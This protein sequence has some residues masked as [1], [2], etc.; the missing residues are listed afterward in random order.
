MPK[1]IKP[2]VTYY[3]D[4][5]NRNKK[6]L[7]PIKANITINY[8]NSSKII[9]HTLPSDWNSKRQ[10]VK[11][12]RPGK[13][14]NHETINKKLEMVQND[15]EN[16]VD[17][18]FL[19][20][21]PLTPDIAKQFFQG[22]R[23]ATEKSFW[24]AYEEYIAGLKV[25]PKTKQNYEL[26]KTKLSEFETDTGYFV[27]YHTINSVFFEKYQHYILNTKGLSWNTFATAIK[28]LKFF[29]NWSYKLKYHIETEFHDFSATEKDK[30]IIFLTIDELTTL[31]NYKFESKRLNQ[32]RDRYCFGC[33]TGLAFADLDN[34]VHDHINN[35]TISKLRKK[36]K[37]PLNIPLPKQALDIIDRYKGKYKVLPKIS[38][39][40][41]NDY[42]SECCEIAKINTPVVYKTYPKGKETE[43]I[44]PKH[45]LI[46][47]HTARKTF[48]SY[49]YYTTKDMILTAKIAGC[50]PDIIKKH[51]IGIHNDQAKEAIKKAFGEL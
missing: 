35:D 25:E 46:K 33:F 24:P 23:I 19:N 30:T 26:Y 18:C 36:T 49:M 15:F 44:A 29:M 41:F 21:I 28:K 50:S 42:I 12:P 10:R 11:P 4:K 39:Q 16:F 34:L 17:N 8:K 7:A 5:N 6:G 48:I 22:K 51:Y 20:R 32:V 37:I 9:D 1:R 2:K 13:T 43:N 47:S 40:K 3:I 14:N 45:K 31:Y 27:D 38:V